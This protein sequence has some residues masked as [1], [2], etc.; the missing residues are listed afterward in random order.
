[1][2]HSKQTTRRKQRNTAIIK[3]LYLAIVNCKNV[4]DL[5]LHHEAEFGCNDAPCP[6][7]L[8]NMWSVIGPN[9]RKLQII[10]PWDRLSLLLEAG[11]TLPVAN[12]EELSITFILLRSFDFM[13]WS[14]TPLA[15]SRP[16]IQFA[17]SQRH[18]L[19]SLTISSFERLDMSS[20]FGELGYFPCLRQL[21]ILVI[22]DHL[23]LPNPSTLTRFL[24]AHKATLESIIIVPKIEEM[25]KTYSSWISGEFTN[26][27]LPALQSLKIGFWGHAFPKVP[28]LTSLSLSVHH[29]DCIPL[30]IEELERSSG[31]RKVKR[32]TRITTTELKV[33]LMPPIGQVTHHKFTSGFYDEWL[34]TV[35]LNVLC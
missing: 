10:S 23:A 32:V 7:F 29:S 30:M 9:L 6:V 16:F 13:T 1:M 19:R 27:D 33:E 3:A 25:D 11:A 28:R 22:I 4:R 24:D 12:L 14:P 34:I 17:Q 31:N 5:T 21:R 8:E 15:I 2:R 35:S 18:S 26:L 20:Y